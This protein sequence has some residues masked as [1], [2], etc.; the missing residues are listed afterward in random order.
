M[1]V[2]ISVHCHFYNYGVNNRAT[3][4]ILIII[5]YVIKIIVVIQMKFAE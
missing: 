1:I 2:F 3:L 4:F 5:A